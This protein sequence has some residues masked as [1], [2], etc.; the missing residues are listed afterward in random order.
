MKKTGELLKQKRESTELSISEVALA[1]KINPKI[2]SA[3]ES[4]D[5]AALPAK[6]FLKGFVRS[7]ALFLKMDVEDVMRTFLEETGGAPAPTVHEAYQ[8]PPEGTPEQPAKRRKV[9][10]ESSSSMR[11][12]A[13]IVI[14][15]LIGL[16][17]GVRELIE[18]YQK[19]KVVA[20][21][22]D[23]KV[24]PLATPPVEPQPAPKTEEP[25]APEKPAEV[26]KD[27]EPKKEEPKKEEPKKEEPKKEEP[28]AI[29]GIPPGLAAPKDEPKKPE[30]KVEP[31]TPKDDRKPTET[32]AEAPKP[33]P[34]KPAEP[35]K[36]TKAGK[37]EV[38]L[39]AL[40]N[41]EVKFSV[42]GEAKRLALAPTQ[43]HT[44]QTDGPM[45][46][47]VSDGGALNIIVNG[48]ERGPVG[49]LGKAKQVTVP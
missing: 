49:P 39:E 6:T 29:A 10:H 22:D 38:I 46:L 45:T 33:E 3:I 16:I 9:D 42:K 1:T 13:V 36:S 23:V 37:F 35:T 14:V 2:L 11:T 17:I 34:V 27:E 12:A 30:P 43:V 24:T 47:D 21:A 7:Y 26:A 5:E 8:K 28:K 44:I 15:L 4:G 25:A 40:D 31:P 20:T 41:V 19:E 32:V 18:K 48:R